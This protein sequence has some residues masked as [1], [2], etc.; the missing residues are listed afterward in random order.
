MKRWMMLALGI[1]GSMLML[2]TIGCG[3][4]ERSVPPEPTIAGSITEGGVEADRVVVSRS[5]DFAQVNERPYVIFED[6]DEMDTFAD[7]MKSGNKINGT[8]DVDF[9]DY[10]IVIDQNGKRSTLHMWLHRDGGQGMFVYT[11]DTGTGYTMTEKS[12]KA[13]IEIIWGVHYD[14][15]TAAA[16]GDVVSPL[17]GGIQNADRWLSFVDNVENKEPDEVQVVYYTI[18]GDPIFR[19][20]IY[21]GGDSL[22]FRLDTSHDDYGA[23]LD[24]TDFCRSIE[25]DKTDAG[26][27]YTLAGCGDSET[28]FELIFPGE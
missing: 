5:I 27:V 1:L 8:L 16:N 23:A 19:N 25:A 2:L 10:D 20:L 18:E 22:R 14:S 15:D 28:W 4:E 13:L 26:T 3:K 9:P 6:G 11:G 24:R 21:D 7:A 17:S 12:T